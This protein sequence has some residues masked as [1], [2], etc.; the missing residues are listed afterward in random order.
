MFSRL[1]F[2]LPNRKG[3]YFENRSEGVV[4][5]ESEKVRDLVQWLE[6]KVAA[7]TAEWRETFD[8][9]P[10]AVL[11]LDEER[12]IKKA[13][14]AATRLFKRS[15]KTLEGIPW[16][17]VVPPQVCNL[18]DLSLQTG[19]GNHTVTAQWPDGRWHLLSLNA[20]ADGRRFLWMAQDISKEKQSEMSALTRKQELSILFDM[21]ELLNH[22]KH[23]QPLLQQAL[24]YLLPKLAGLWGGKVE[25]R[26]GVFLLDGAAGVL[27]LM[28]NIGLPVDLVAKES[29]IP[30][31]HCLCGIAAA[32][33]KV[34]T[35]SGTRRAQATGYPPCI[36]E[37][38]G[39][40]AQVIIPLLGEKGVEGVLFLYF[41]AGHRF[42]AE[43]KDFLR[44][45]GHVLG[46]AVY[47]TRL[48]EE[49]QAKANQDGLTG[50][51][52]HNEFQRRLQEEV[53]RVVRYNR[54]LSLLM[55]DIDHFKRVNDTYG[56]PQ[57]DLV[58]KTVGEV[59]R[60]SRRGSDVA[61]R[62]GGEEF[63]V[64]LPEVGLNAAITAAERLRQ[65]VAKRLIPL[66]EKTISVTVS[67]GVGTLGGPVTDA[68][69]LVGAADK[70]LYA[71]KAAGR[72]RVEATGLVKLEDPTA[73]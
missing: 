52:N 14:A 33:R 50:L 66:G 12:R 62:Y 69:A 53:K 19:K 61:A 64:L 41:Q 55:L 60:E 7:Q 45:V 15:P 22:A 63:A 51:N 47:N 16:Q 6:T 2:L 57:G 18:D 27:R 68:V 30:L 34:I 31:G 17:T 56:H 21:A 9:M 23:K 43:E 4:Q 32:K 28:V 29:E 11:I 36:C 1:A 58:L 37:S 73:V 48:R 8:A 59:L 54:P 42:A 72:N 70:A 65:T 24:N 71:A 38:S 5:V 3:A 46:M 44:S 39:D 25:R 20:V 49:L 35:I 40:Y 10:A 67:I 13:N 26:G